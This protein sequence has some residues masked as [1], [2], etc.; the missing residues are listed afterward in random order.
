MLMVEPPSEPRLPMLCE[1]V[2]LEGGCV[3]HRD[4]DSTYVLWVLQAAPPACPAHVVFL[5]KR[6]LNALRYTDGQTFLQL[7][8]RRSPEECCKMISRTLLGALRF[9]PDYIVIVSDEDRDGMPLASGLSM[10][11]A[12]TF[13]PPDLRGICA[14]AEGLP[15]LEGKRE[16]AVAESGHAPSLPLSNLLGVRLSVLCRLLSDR[17]FFHDPKTLHYRQRRRQSLSM[18]TVPATR[19]D[20]IQVS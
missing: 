7:L 12:L 20:V 8:G 2:R 6:W 13:A 15:S 4:M 16:E 17:G 19:A 18:D 11:T 1:C 10:A 3:E 5:H 14:L 9:R